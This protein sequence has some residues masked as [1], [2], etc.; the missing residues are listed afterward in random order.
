MSAPGD[1][2]KWYPGKYAG[3]RRSSA[4]SSPIEKGSVSAESKQTDTQISSTHVEHSTNAEGKEKWYPGKMM[5]RLSAYDITSQDQGKSSR[6]SEVTTS[7]AHTTKDTSKMDLVSI[8][9][10]TVTIEKLKYFSIASCIILMSVD[11]NV[12]TPHNIANLS[13]DCDRDIKCIIP[14]TDISSSL[15]I[16]FL[17]SSTQNSFGR[18]VIPL[19]HYLSATK[20]KN[21]VVEWRQLYPPYKN[22]ESPDRFRTGYDTIFDHAMS[23]PKDAIGFAKVSCHI[24]LNRSIL[25]C[26]TLNRWNPHHETQSIKV[27]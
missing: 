24:E 5:R 17:D 2:S 23:R 8:G 25:D 1:N 19:D 9:N 12:Q 3:L 13:S 10:I 16:Q 14:I 22:N 27:E 26:L 20:P 6:L 15:L 18:I 4:S 11:D 7:A 21:V